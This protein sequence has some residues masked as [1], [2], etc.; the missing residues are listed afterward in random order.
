MSAATATAS[1][2]TGPSFFGKAFAL[3]QRIGKAL[4]VP[5]AILPAAGLL[6]GL[7]AGAQN[8]YKQI[9]DT[10]AV[11]DGLFKLITDTMTGAGDI[12]FAN[13]PLLFALGVAIGLTGDAGV[14]ALAGTVGFLIMNKTIQVFGQVSVAVDENGAPLVT[15]DCAAA[16]CF[17]ADGLGSISD[18]TSPGFTSVLGIPSLQMGVFGGILVGIVAAWAYNKYF[19]ISLPPY[20]GFFAGKRF[21]PIA[22]ATFCLLLGILMTFV[23]PPIGEAINAFADAIKGLGAI[24]VFIFGLVERSLIPFGLHH[25]FYSPFWFQFGEWTNLDTG[26]VFTGDQRM[27]F[28]QLSADAEF[29]DNEGDPTGRY[30]TGK[31]PFMMFGLPAA[32][33]AMYHEAKTHR[34]KVAAGI[35]ASAALTSFL[36]GITEPIEFTFLFVAPLLF[37]VHAVI[38]GL[39]FMVMYITGTQIGLTFSGGLIDFF[40]FGILPNREPWWNVILFGL[41]L[42]PIYYFLFRWW[43]RKFDIATPGREPDLVEED[44]VPGGHMSEQTIAHGVLAALGGRKNITNLDACITR[45]R[46]SVADPSAVDKDLLKS[47][48]AAGVLEVSGGVQAIF[49]PKAEQLKDEVKALIDAGVDGAAPKTAVATLDAPGPDA[50]EAEKLIFYFGGKEN[51]KSLEACITRLR[52]EVR[53]KS[54]V[55]VAKIKSLGAAGV[56]EVGNNMQAIFGPRAD[57]LRGEMMKYM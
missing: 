40:I 32:A 37:A 29:V 45:L 47:L 25:I 54:K 33:L 23:W 24:G 12:V 7:G 53:D 27:W 28:G 43:I 34:R 20:L 49:G 26:Q 13:L 17:Q 39:S 2:D 57:A 1:T 6:L 8:V 18:L 56:V 46:V 30:M 31:F 11:P 55:D 19:T 38:A 21:V 50:S 16:P 44:D 22:T 51:I 42:M 36:T 14:A 3:L 35:L 15:E 52:V 10:D 5:V 48:G 4:M 9:N 41:A